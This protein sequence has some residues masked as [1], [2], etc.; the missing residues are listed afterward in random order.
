MAA[1]R[2]ARVWGREK[3]A[4]PIAGPETGSRT[5]KRLQKHA[6]LQERSTVLHCSTCSETLKMIHHRF[7]RSIPKI[8]MFL[9][10]ED[11]IPHEIHHRGRPA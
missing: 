5:H 1:M 6:M 2:E 4:W 10:Q 8:D 7:P 3:P 11:G 9:V